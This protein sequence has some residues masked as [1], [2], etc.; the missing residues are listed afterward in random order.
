[1][2]EIGMDGLGGMNVLHIVGKLT[3]PVYSFLGPASEALAKAGY[4]QTIVM[5]DVARYRHLQYKL[6]S[7]AH[8]EIIP[9]EP[10]VWRNWVAMNKL[11]Q[12]LIEQNGFSA[13]HM[14]GFRAWALGTRMGLLLPRHAKVFYSPHGSRTLT[15]MRP[16]Q[17]AL[18]SSMAALGSRRPQI[19]AST[20][21]DARRASRG[22][23]GRRITTIE[24]AV[25]GV[26][27]DQAPCESRRPLLV[28]GD[29]TRNHRSVEMF[30]RLAVVMGAAELG[31]SFNWLGKPD[32]ASQA[33]L[34]AANVGIFPETEAADVAA[35]L[36]SAWIFVAPSDAEGFPVML[37]RAMAVGL[38]CVV[39]RTPYHTDLIVHEKN[40]LVYDTEADALSMI[41]RLI[42]DPGLR[43]RLG[44]AAKADANARLTAHRLDGALIAAYARGGSGSAS[45]GASQRLAHV[46]SKQEAR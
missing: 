4:R 36:A 32:S 17:S 42:D 21:S 24:S 5:L 6:P 23:V 31:L 13:Y 33:R 38:P 20:Q 3:E 12:E 41:S 28:S 39:L 25:E 35:K 2:Q 30:C 37:A 27:F 34:K 1:M 44:A 11:I 40:G 43:A 29:V 18:G 14:H 45:A 22:T 7:Q 16:L 15:L 19:I 10:S 26:Y 46:A 9:V 8:V